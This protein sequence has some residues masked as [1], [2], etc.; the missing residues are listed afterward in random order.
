MAFYYVLTGGTTQSVV[1]KPRAKR[2][3]LKLK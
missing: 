1:Q 2:V 3:R